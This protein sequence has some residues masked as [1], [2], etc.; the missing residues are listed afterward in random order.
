MS[1]ISAMRRRRSLESSVVWVMSP[2]KAMKSGWRD[3]ALMAATTFLNVPAG[4]R[5]DL[6]VLEAPVGVRELDEEEVFGRRRRC[7]AIALRRRRRRDG[8]AEHDAEAAKAGKREQFTTI[9]VVAHDLMLLA[10]IG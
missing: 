4:V 8:R 6:V 5:V 7:G 2:V 9:E 1:R 10:E 3:S